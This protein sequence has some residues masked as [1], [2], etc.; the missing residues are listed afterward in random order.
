MCPRQDHTW[1]TEN[2]SS[3]SAPDRTAPIDRRIARAGLSS[4]F[5]G[6]TVFLEG[7]GGAVGQGVGLVGW[8]ELVS[9]P[10]W[11]DTQAVTGSRQATPPDPV[12][13][14]LRSASHPQTVRHELLS[15]ACC[16]SCCAGR[17][18]CSASRVHWSGKSSI[19]AVIQST[20]ADR[21]RHVVLG[22]ED[23]VHAKGSGRKQS[24]GRILR[25]TSR[26]LLCQNSPP[27]GVNMCAGSS[28]GGRGDLHVC[29]SDHASVPTWAGRQ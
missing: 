14:A 18:G 24:A 23:S 19:A 2:G 12:P 29:R 1:W 22:D 21:H 9:C 17:V 28:L 13:P 4:L 8:R 15:R 3:A 26:T 7:S 6:R 25:L 27:V 20:F 16:E 10:S 11:S 5:H